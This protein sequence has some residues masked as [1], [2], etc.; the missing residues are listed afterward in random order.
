MW[1]KILSIFC[2]LIVAV[3]LPIGSM[4]WLTAFANRP[5]MESEIARKF[6]VK[7]RLIIW[8]MSLVIG[9]VIAINGYQIY[10]ILLNLFYKLFY[11]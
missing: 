5:C 4:L 11:L 7:L 3:G 8:A 2:I 1:I 6:G 9:T 10:E